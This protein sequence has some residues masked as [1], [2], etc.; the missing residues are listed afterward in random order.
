MSLFCLRIL[1]FQYINEWIKIKNKPV[2][3]LAVPPLG[4]SQGWK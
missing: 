1:Y 3:M 4:Q 2:E